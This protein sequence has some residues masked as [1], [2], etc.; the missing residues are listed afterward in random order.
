MSDNKSSATHLFHIEVKHL[1]KQK[2]I[3]NELT[4][5]HPVKEV[6]LSLPASNSHV[7]NKQSR[8]K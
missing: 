1:D 2:T 5:I 7:G 4:K 8:K 6:T 3:E